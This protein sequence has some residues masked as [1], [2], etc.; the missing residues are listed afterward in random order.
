MPPASG[1]LWTTKWNGCSAMCGGDALGSQAFAVDVP[2]AARQW[3][4][5]HGTS[6][7]YGARELK[8]TVHRHLTQPLA[9]MVTQGRIGPGNNVRVG[10]RA[11]RQSLTLR[12]GKESD[13]RGAR[14][15]R[16][17]WWWT[18]IAS[19]CSFWSG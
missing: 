16:R 4:L 14:L 17:C 5:E 7:E 10:V 6:V 3:L 8:R 12:V 2:F 19:C 18:A 1:R 11:D 9:T 15:C 13:V